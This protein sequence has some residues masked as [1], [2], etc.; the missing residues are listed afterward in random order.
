MQRSGFGSA[1]NELSQL[2]S[3]ALVVPFLRRPRRRRWAGG[4]ASGAQA[5][6]RGRHG[7]LVLVAGTAPDEVVVELIHRAGGRRARAAVVAAASFASVPAGERYRRY[8]ARFGMEQVATV[9]LSTRLRA[10]RPDPALEAADLVVVGGANPELLVARLADTAALRGLLAA[11]SRGAVLAFLGAAAE[12]A[13]A[14]WLAPPGEDPPLRPGLGLLPGTCV[15]TDAPIAHLVATALAT[16]VQAVALDAGSAVVVGADGRAQVRA[17]AVLAVGGTP[18]GGAERPPLGGVYARVAPAGWYLDLA[19][20][21][22]LPPGATG[23]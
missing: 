8:L 14:W 5:P 22:V 7:P 6:A 2:L 18:G 12:A 21:R 19:A 13:G 15:A 11:W 17:G 20:R 16:G 10:D 4:R 3:Q 23:A 9:D 1:V